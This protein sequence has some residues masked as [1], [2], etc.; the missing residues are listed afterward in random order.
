MTNDK[1][2]MALKEWAVAVD[3]LVQGKTIL[4][5]RK[6][7]IR[8]DG[9]RFQV[10]HRQ[11]LLYPTYEHQN[12]ELLKPE[13]AQ[14]TPVASG[15]HPETVPISA[16]AEIDTILQVTDEDKVERLLPYHVW[17]QRWVEERL[18]WKPRQ[19]LYLLLLRTYKL[20]Q[21]HQIPYRPG[22]GGCRSWIEIATPI[23]VEGGTPVLTDTE[24]HEL[25]R[26]ILSRVA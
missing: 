1:G 12:P 5:L 16:W 6:G 22:Y 10:P 25:A 18:Q 15:W 14:V 2:Q 23:S 20:S 11:V 7:G 13:Y 8:E 19:P 26:D 24:Y 21:P 4:L 17:N 9:G 3:A